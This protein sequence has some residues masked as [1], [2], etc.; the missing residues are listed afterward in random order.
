VPAFGLSSF[1]EDGCGHLYAVHYSGDSVY[2]V[3][4]GAFVAC[5]R[6]P[7][8]PG[9]PP[10][11]DPPPGEPGPAPDTTR[12]VLRLGGA[13]AQRALRKRR[14][15]VSAR[16]D[17]SCALDATGLLRRPPGVSGPPANRATRKTAAGARV[18]LELRLKAR[19][20]R[21]LRTLLRGGGRGLMRVRVVARDDAGNRTTATRHIAIVRR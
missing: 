3:D 5:P 13:K 9:D 8:P 18:T 14:V 6:P 19:A 16:C 17:E 2:R 4:D 12:P 7:A 10:P 1:G 21:A 11:P 20:V 15:L